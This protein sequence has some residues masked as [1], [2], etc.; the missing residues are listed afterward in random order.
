MDAKSAV[1]VQ[2][3]IIWLHCHRQRIISMHWTSFPWKVIRTFTVASTKTSLYLLLD[4]F[5]NEDTTYQ[6]FVSGAVVYGTPESAT[7]AKEKRLFSHTFILTVDT[8]SST[9]VIANECFRFH[10]WEETANHCVIVIPI[11]TDKQIFIVLM[12]WTSMYII[13]HVILLDVCVRH[14]SS[15]HMIRMIHN[16]ITSIYMLLTMI[17]N[18][19][20]ERVVGQVKKIVQNHVIVVDFQ[21][22]IRLRLLRE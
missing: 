20:I 14:M 9:W 2:L 17:N 10:E 8:S 6:V 11:N 18:K 19:Q 12:Y 16:K 1:L 15:I 3:L 13:L 4:L 22:N 7:A 21:R 5:P